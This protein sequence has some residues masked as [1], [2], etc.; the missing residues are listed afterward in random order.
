M[1]LE[2]IGNSSNNNAS[3]LALQD[4]IRYIYD[5]APFDGTLDAFHIR[6]SS[7]GA[8]EY[9][10][11]AI[12]VS[13]S[14][15]LVA[16]SSI[17]E[18]GATG[19]S[20]SIGPSSLTKGETY[21]IAVWGDELSKAVWRDDSGDY[22]LSAISRDFDSTSPEGDFTT[23][24]PLDASFNKYT[25]GT[26]KIWATY[27]PN[28]IGD[29]NIYYSSLSYPH[30][31]NCKCSRWDI[32]DYTFVIETWLTKSQLKTIRDHIRPGAVGE[33]VKLYERP[34]YKDKSWKNDNTLMFSPDTLNSS[35]LK[36]M[37]QERL[38]YVKNITDIPLTG[39]SKLLNVKIEG[40]VSGNLGL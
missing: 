22:W 33:F 20:G 40:Y 1:V 32:Q 14:R 30:Y 8:G 15:T 37:R 27:I 38:M 21:L 26:L 23:L 5:T 10:R 16:Q 29:L 12:Y 28:Y 3:T 24:D 13:S 6:S 7:W 9:G 35:T 18:G 25:T 34:I 36:A 39:P 31:I 19:I 17:L 11:G 2:I 4:T